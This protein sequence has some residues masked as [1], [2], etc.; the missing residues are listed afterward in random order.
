MQFIS[1]LDVSGGAVV[2]K[3]MAVNIGDTRDVGLMPVSGRSCGVG[4][5][6]LFQYS[7]LENPW[8]RILVGYTPQGHKELDTT[9]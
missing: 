9:E 6:N 7:C 3:K 5:V 4:N 1:S 2:K 8:M